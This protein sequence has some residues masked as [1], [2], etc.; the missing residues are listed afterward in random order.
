MP[1]FHCL[2]LILFVHCISVHQIELVA[3]RN[4][5]EEA[6]Y[7]YGSWEPIHCDDLLAILVQLFHDTKNSYKSIED[8]QILA[9]LTLNFIQNLY[10]V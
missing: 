4:A 8:P 5:F 3:I 2:Q 1:Y 9:D 6:G 7:Q 10:D